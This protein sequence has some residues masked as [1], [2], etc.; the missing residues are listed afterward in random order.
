M[1]PS[2]LRD[3]IF[4]K[5]NLHEHRHLACLDFLFKS[6]YLDMLIDISCFYYGNGALK[7]CIVQVLARD[8]NV[9]GN[10]FVVL[11]VGVVNNLFGILGLHGH[12]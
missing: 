10:Q 11:C 4:E 8:E 1:H 9:F 7:Y 3:V 2:F 5:Y 12:F 6:Y